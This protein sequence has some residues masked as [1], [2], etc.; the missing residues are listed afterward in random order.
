MEKHENLKTDY[1][2]H[3][4]SSVLKVLSE[5]VFGMQDGMVSTLGSVA[6]IAIGSG[7]HKTVILAGV[8]IIAVESISMGI[9][10]YVSNRSEE[11]VDE[12]KIAEEKEE[13][14]NNPEE[15][16]IELHEMYVR[17]GWSQ[18][19]A[20]QMVN[21]AASNH[22]LMLKEMMIR[23]LKIAQEPESLSVRGGIFMFFSYIVG[24]LVPLSSYIFLP[25]HSAI[26]T[27]IVIT[28]LGLFLLGVG[29]TRFTHQP[30]LKAGVRILIMG[31]IALCAGLIAGIML[32]Q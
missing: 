27:S 10:S 12:R 31:G 16:K 4:Q 23:E 22:D 19:L 9:G 32:G 18:E 8:V 15:E 1:I 29:T 25:I 21:E 14:H 7:N 28:L 6:G 17:D 20:T 30:K 3:Q 26:P 24:G 2:H 13:L 5:I 11:E